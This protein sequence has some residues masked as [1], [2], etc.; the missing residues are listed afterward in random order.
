MRLV[1][2]IPHEKYKIQIFQFSGEYILKIELGQFEQTYRVKET[3]VEGVE[4]VQK[5]LKQ[6]LLIGAL[7]RFIE[8]RSDWANAFK[9]KNTL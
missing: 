5:L 2:I 4:G 7:H 1:R 8:M 9:V 3:A 6:E